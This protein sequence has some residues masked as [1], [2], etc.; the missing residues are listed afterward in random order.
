M[1]MWVYNE[2]EAPIVARDLYIRQEPWALVAALLG[3]RSMLHSFWDDCESP[4]SM[5]ISSWVGRET[6]AM[7]CDCYWVFSATQV[8]LFCAT[9]A[10]VVLDI[11]AGAGLGLF[12]GSLDSKKE[13]DSTCIDWCH[14]G[15][16]SR[17]LPGK[18]DFFCLHLF[19]LWRLT[20]PA[21]LPTDLFGMS[22]PSPCAIQL[23]SVVCDSHSGG[24][25]SSLDCAYIA[26]LS[27]CIMGPC[28]GGD[29]ESPGLCQSWIWAWLVTTI[30]F[31][32][33]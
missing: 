4:S 15:L 7:H 9:A 25:A 18:V 22:S 30:F 2:V 33:Q 12:L 11:L 28:F 6:Y 19:L 13:G 1:Y 24:H 32:C 23:L 26:W 5:V 8:P 3:R 20:P 31:L 29:V 16:I 21:C 27:C 10:L 17:V 14:G